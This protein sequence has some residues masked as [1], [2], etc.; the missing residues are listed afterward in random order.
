MNLLAFL[1]EK[2]QTL[3]SLANFYQVANLKAIDNQ[4]SSAYGTEQ[5]QQYQ[6]EH[7]RLKSMSRQLAGTER[8]NYDSTISEFKIIAIMTFN[9]LDLEDLLE[10]KKHT[11]KIP[12][13][14]LIY[15]VVY[16]HLTTTY[17]KLIDSIDTPKLF[18][19][20]YK[21][22]KNQTLKTELVFLEVILHD[23]EK[24][25]ESGSM[26]K[27]SNNI[28]KIIN[29][30]LDFGYDI[31]EENGL[32]SLSYKKAEYFYRIE[33]DII[34]DFKVTSDEQYKNNMT[35]SLQ[36]TLSNAIE[37]IKTKINEQSE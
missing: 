7:N 21:N 25:K 8:R 29:Q 6:H 20:L 22:F 2:H 11:Q 5:H 18:E 3:R 10:V 24:N 19:V 16:F 26:L 1:K 37:V 12:L 28:S 15:H 9:N 17:R 23:V 36:S 32:L 4:R 14:E 33:Q 35:L 30:I 31:T 13:S 27:E 34:N